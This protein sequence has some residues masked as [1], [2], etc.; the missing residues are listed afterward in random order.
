MAFFDKVGAGEITTRITLDTRLIQDGIS[1]KS[2][3]FL[4]SISSFV[5]ALGIAFVT[6]WKL[7]LELTSTIV[8]MIAVIGIGTFFV[9]RCSKRSL[10]AYALGGSTAQEAISSIREVSALGTQ[11]TLATHYDRHLTEA[12][13]WGIKAKSALGLMIAFVMGGLVLAYV[14]GNPHLLLMP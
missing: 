8:F 2:A 9:V 12:E 13:K 11:N 5:G 3:L 6:Y 14:G 7:T 4:T 10:E 1:Q